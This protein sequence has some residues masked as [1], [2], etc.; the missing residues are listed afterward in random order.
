VPGCA[1]LPTPSE[2]WGSG[3]TPRRPNIWAMLQGLDQRSKIE[4]A[5]RWRAREAQMWDNAE[6]GELDPT[7][8]LRRRLQEEFFH[9][10]LH[11]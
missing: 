10:I 2:V 5:Q 4:V 11:R 6:V 1:V 3:G 9:F 7:E 8:G